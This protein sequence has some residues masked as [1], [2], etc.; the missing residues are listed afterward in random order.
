M[1]TQGIRQSLAAMAMMVSGWSG[2]ALSTDSAGQPLPAAPEPTVQAVGGGLGPDGQQAQNPNGAL[3]QITEEQNGGLVALAPMDELQVL[4]EGNP[5][6]GFGW[7]A[8]HLEEAML[9]PVGVP[10]FL[11]YSDLAGSGGNFMLTFRA[12]KPGAT[13]LRLLYRRPFEP[14]RPPERLYEVAIEIQ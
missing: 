9:Q 8:D 6:T 12:L 7:L 13:R 2:Q 14:D 5:T 1:H 10:V 4:I 11:P 3:V